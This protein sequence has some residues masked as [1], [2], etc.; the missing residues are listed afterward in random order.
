MYGFSPVDA[1]T[2]MIRST[3][4]VPAV[5]FPVVVPVEVPVPEAELPGPALPG[6]V[7]VAA[8]AEVPGPAVSTS[9]AVTRSVS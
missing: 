4:V 7:N 2:F 1:A 5:V 3:Y 6:A 9:G 8:P